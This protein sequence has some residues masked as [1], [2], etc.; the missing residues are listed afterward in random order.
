MKEDPGMRK[1]IR[2][3]GRSLEERYGYRVSFAAGFLK[4]TFDIVCDSVYSPEKDKGLLVKIAINT[5]SKEE[6]EAIKNYISWK[7]K[8][9]WILRFGKSPSDPGKILKYR[10]EDDRIIEEPPY[11][12]L[13]RIMSTRENRQAKAQKEGAKSAKT[14]G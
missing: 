7:K 12:P 6:V 9:L 3:I 11:W 4:K 1:A 14:G 5:V 13:K 10:I 8:E 2:R